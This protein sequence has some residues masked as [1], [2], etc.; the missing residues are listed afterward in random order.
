MS[1]EEA[2]AFRAR[3]QLVNAREIE[4]LRNTS[5]DVKWQQFNTLLRW[6]DQFG[7]GSEL[8]K[9]EG[10]VRERWARLRREFRG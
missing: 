8:A 7:W 10:L 5:L 3:W 9:D 4:E 1:K 6:V 2:Q